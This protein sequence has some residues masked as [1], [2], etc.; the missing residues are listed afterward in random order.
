MDGLK[1][2]KSWVKRLQE[3]STIR[4]RKFCSIT[5]VVK[6]S[7]LSKFF[8]DILVWVG[9]GNANALYVKRLVY[10]EFWFSCF[11]AFSAKKVKK[12]L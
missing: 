10:G 6:W 11:P 1:S 5:L 9:M 8:L 3:I 7:C 12:M 4:L 2:S